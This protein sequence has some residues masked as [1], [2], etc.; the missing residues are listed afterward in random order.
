MR[1]HPIIVVAV[2]LVAALLG[3]CP[4][5]QEIRLAK[6]SAYDAD[7]AIVY[8][9]TV[10]AVRELYPNLD[11]D[12]STGVIRTAW[13][14]V[15]YSG[16][17][18]DTRT[19]D[20]RATGQ[21]PGTGGG[22]FTSP[23]SALNTKV[24][25][26][27]DVVVA[28]GRPW[29]IRVVARASEWDAGNAEP[30]E[31]KGAATPHWVPGRRDALIVAIYRRLKEYAIHIEEEEAEIESPVAPEVD[32][33]T[34]GDIPDGARKTATAIVQAVEIRDLGALRAQVARDVVW[35]FGAEGDVDTALV[36]WQA[37]PAT[38]DALAKVLRAGCRAGD[39]VV[40]CPP[41][42]TESPGYL[43]WRATLEERD[44]AWK[45]TAFVQGD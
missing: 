42:A 18:E 7:F 36:M 19:G 44:G 32:P 37:D 24:F 17:N 35:S 13:H 29:R 41:E 9:E 11:D 4:S 1:P 33:A 14:Q 3:G 43:G 10:A 38:L 15:Q 28:G 25:I 8:S 39:A 6:S 31:L 27:F 16:G 40:T 21:N 20:P 45:L 5:T 26:R 12:P 23:A 22:A 30:T 2:T 34:F